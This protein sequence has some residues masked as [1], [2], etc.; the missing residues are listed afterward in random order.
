M[1]AIKP[2]ILLA[3]VPRSNSVHDSNAS[4]SH[5]LAPAATVRQRLKR[6]TNKYEQSAMTA[7]QNR[8]VV[9]HKAQ[10]CR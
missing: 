5:A 4:G 2:D 8:D 10:Q 1:V 9:Q 3:I 7:P 6:I